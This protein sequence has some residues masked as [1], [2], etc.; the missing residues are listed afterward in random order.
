MQW[1]GLCSS[2]AHPSSRALRLRWTC[3]V[4]VRMSPAC[5][6]AVCATARHATSKPLLPCLANQHPQDQV[7][8]A[9]MRGMLPTVAQSTRQVP[10]LGLIFRGVM[11]AAAASRQAAGLG[12]ALPAA[13]SASAA[14]A[15]LVLNMQLLAKAAAA[16]P[17]PPAMMSMG[18]KG[19]GWEHYEQLVAALLSMPPGPAT[20]TALRSVLPLLELVLHHGSGTVSCSCRACTLHTAM[21]HAEVTPRCLRLPLLA[22][23]CSTAHAGPAVHMCRLTL[24]HVCVR[25]RVCACVQR[26]HCH[27]S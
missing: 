3:G 16:R 15:K 2:Q 25:M 20:R 9:A 7:V 21:P 10:D 14:V 24:A 23:M 6:G 27:G 11:T 17:A 22:Y 8:L 26:I 13:P 1:L 19:V 5:T 12:K 4:I 18:V